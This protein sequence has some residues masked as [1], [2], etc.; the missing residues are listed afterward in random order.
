VG[1]VEEEEEEE[2][3]EEDAEEEEEEE[4]EEGDD[5]TE[6]EEKDAMVGSGETASCVVSVAPPVSLIVAFPSAAF[7]S[8][9]SGK[10]LST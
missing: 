2:E 3:E 7:C 5:E 6:G 8:I 1:E 10:S 9:V 4:E